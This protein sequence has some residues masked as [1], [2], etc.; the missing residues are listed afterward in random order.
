MWAT[1]YLLVV[2]VLIVVTFKT[3]TYWWCY[4]DIF[5]AFMAAFCHL[6]SRL[7]ERIIPAESVR[8]DKIALWM[9]I[10]MVVALVAESVALYSI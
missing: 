5:F 10:A 1:I 9:T 3:R 4:F 6:M 8:L 2:V 7:I